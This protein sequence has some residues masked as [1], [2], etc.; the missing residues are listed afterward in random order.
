MHGANLAWVSSFADEAAVHV[1]L[2]GELVESLRRVAERRRAVVKVSVQIVE[3]PGGGFVEQT[4]E[5]LHPALAVGGERRL[6]RAAVDAE[7]QHADDLIFP[8]DLVDEILVFLDI[9]LEGRQ[10]F[11]RLGVSANVRIL[12]R[13]PHVFVRLL[14]V[15]EKHLGL[16]HDEGDAVIDGDDLFERRVL[17]PGDAIKNDANGSP[18]APSSGPSLG[19]ADTVPMSSRH[20]SWIRSKTHCTS[21]LSS[22]L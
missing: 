9:R 20:T 14:P 21:G 19:T 1:H 6:E 5:L 16:L 18:S 3:L 2:V 8:R 4:R 12:I 17:V 7:K 13:L 10:R 15:P 22:T 11:P